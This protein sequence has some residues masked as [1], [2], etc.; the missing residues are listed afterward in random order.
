M[1]GDPSDARLSAPE[2][3]LAAIASAQR[4]DR[5]LVELASLAEM[6]MNTVVGLVLNGAIVIGRIVSPQAMAHAVDEHIL[7]S[8]KMSA[9]ASPHDATAWEEAK[10][11]V[12]G[13]NVKVVQEER[14]ARQGMIAR[15]RELYGDARV[16]PTEMPEDL[17]R[18]IIDDATR[19]TIT[20]ADAHIFPPG[21]RE[22]IDVS[23]MRV[24]VRQ[25]GG[26]WIVPA[27]PETRS[28]SFAFPGQS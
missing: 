24:D 23:V 1:T 26:W 20:L 2:A 16:S 13:G 25:V 11:T 8:L 10:Q 22:P 27:D 5:Y 3:N 17:A 4:I 18:D 9:A 6:N 19:V 14:Q 15:H 21:I 7:T 12:G 28:A